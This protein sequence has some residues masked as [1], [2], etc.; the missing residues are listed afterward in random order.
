MSPTEKEVECGENAQLER[1]PE[2]DL[3]QNDTGDQPDQTDDCKARPAEA[4]EADDLQCCIRPSQ[5]PEKSDSN[6]KE[7]PGAVTSTVYGPEEKPNNLESKV[8]SEVFANAEVHTF[9]VEIADQD[10]V[11]KLNSGQTVIVD[12]QI[13]SSA[14][15]LLQP[16]QREEYERV[17]RRRYELTL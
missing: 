16:S 13:K 1:L 10:L 5:S 17:Q 9:S 15:V 6:S 12:A 3:D 11:A 7:T 4:E 8:A 2:D 14:V